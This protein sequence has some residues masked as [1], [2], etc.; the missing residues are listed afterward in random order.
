MI[1]E[2]LETATL[3]DVAPGDAWA[4]Q[5]QALIRMQIYFTGETHQMLKDLAHEARTIIAD[6]FGDETQPDGLTL[7]Q[8]THGIG[9]AW[10][11]MF[12]EWRKRF[13][14]LQREAAEIAFG[15]LAVLHERYVR[16]ALNE[17][18]TLTE[19][20]VNAGDVFAPQ[21]QAVIDAA[22]RRIYA[23]GIPLSSR[24]WKLDRQSRT[25]IERIIYNGVANKQSAWNIAKE[26]EQY[27]GFGANCPRWTSTRL[28]LTKKQIAEGDLAGL[29][30]GEECRGQGVA[31][32]ALRLARNELQVIHG[33]A[34]DQILAG[35]PF[36]EKE[37]IY[38]S[39]SHPEDDECDA[40]IAAGEGGKGIY[41]KGTIT[42]PIHVQCLCGKAAVLPNDDQF[43]DQLRGWLNGS[44]HWSAMDDYQALVGGD[45]SVN[46]SGLL[47]LATLLRWAFNPKPGEGLT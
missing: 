22:N 47:E 6:G 44:Q 7:H 27:L 43:T 4:V 19:A 38:L 17:A 40:V 14:E 41:P 32:N 37:Q 36:V 31:Y 33:L 3:N 21:L 45:V 29:K 12:S 5:Y 18:R 9:Q 30:R 1:A 11:V 42:I 23:D 39:P 13:E 34:T 2:L 20:T 24:L 35:L 10:D 15:G 8:V 26:L 25:E 16:P 28:R 46:L